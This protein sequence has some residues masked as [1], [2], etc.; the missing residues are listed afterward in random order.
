M[1]VAV[2][3]MAGT[4]VADDG[5]VF[6][7]V[8]TALRA[9]RIVPEGPRFP[10]LRRQA[11][12]TMDRSTIAVF[13]EL[14]DGDMH[15]ARRANAAFEA[16]FETQLRA[17]RIH[18]VPGARAAMSA[19]RAAGL[20]VVLSS[21]FAP[22]VRDALIAALGWSD[23]VDLLVCPAD[24]DGRG[25]PDPAMLLA[26]AASVDADPAEVV[27]AGDATSGMLAARRAGTGLAIGVRTGAHGERALRAAGADDVID[28]V[29][30]LPALLGLPS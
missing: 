8:R 6:D 25:L 29:A 23:V 16:C 22:A 14:L 24:V 9:V 1:R 15:R 11:E 18:E 26:A 7:A 2:L 20:T 12:A 3:D 19:L 27:A 21:G 30:D 28:S 5:M 10:A 4:T 13:G 17:G